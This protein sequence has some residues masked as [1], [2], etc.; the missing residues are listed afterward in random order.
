M[1]FENYEF[2]FLICFLFIDVET[3]RREQLRW[4]VAILAS[5]SAAVTSTRT[6]IAPDLQRCLFMS[7]RF[8]YDMF[9]IWEISNTMALINLDFLALRWELPF[10]Y[11]Y[12]WR[13]LEKVHM[14]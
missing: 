1:L 2:L 13:R 10:Q 3:R 7:I 11:V 5:T 8:L 14:R 4:V 6:G 12:I 9:S